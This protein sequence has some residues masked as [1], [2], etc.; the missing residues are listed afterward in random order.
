MKTQKKNNTSSRLLMA[1]SLAASDA[2]KK[3][4]R[5][6]FQRMTEIKS[7]NAN[8]DVSVFAGSLRDFK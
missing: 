6:S 8:V 1:K 3:T 4:M 7:R 5:D 2:F